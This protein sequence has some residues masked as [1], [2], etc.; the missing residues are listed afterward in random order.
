MPREVIGTCPVCGE[1]MVVTETYCPSCDTRICGRFQLDKFAKLTPE[2]RAF[3]EIFIKCRGNIREVERELGISYPTVRSRLDAVIEALGYPAAA[4]SEVQTD[5][6]W[7]ASRRKEI[8]DKLA[9]GEISPAE[10]ATM[11]RSVR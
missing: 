4:D 8:L 5:E 6:G 11:L 3:T 1:A 10:A 2:Q 9:S 7:K